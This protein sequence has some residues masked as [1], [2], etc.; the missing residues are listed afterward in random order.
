MST[1]PERPRLLGALILGAGALG[2]ATSVLVGTAAAIARHLRV[3]IVGDIEIVQTAILVTASAALVA[4]TLASRH[5]SVHLLIDRVPA[6][7]KARL[8]RLN[9]LLSAVFF[10]ALTC[11]LG[12]IT[13]DLRHAHEESE[14][15]HIPY[16][17]LRW[18]ALA[19]ILGS[20]VLSLALV[21]RRDPR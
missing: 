7:T 8:L 20:G 10:L 11:G 3:V 16:A 15:L 2:L 4:A 13:L 9:G 14:L 21:T 1:A 19:A 5:A 6:A 17:P 12:W 18:I